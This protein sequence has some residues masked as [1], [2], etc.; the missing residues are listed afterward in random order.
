VAIRKTFAEVPAAPAREVGVAG[1]V[2]LG[3]AARA[4]LWPAQARIEGGLW[5]RR[6]RVNR[7]VSIPDGAEQLVRAG[8]LDNFRLAAGTGSGEF[9]GKYPF[10]D[11]DV[12]KWLEAAGW[13]LGREPDGALAAR[14]REIVGL[15]AAAQQPDG[16]LNTYF[17]VAKAGRRFTELDWGH[18]MYCAG[19]LIQAGIAHARGTGDTALLD[20]GRKVADNLDSEFGPDGRDGVDGHPEIETALMEL[21]RQ[22]AEKRYRDLAAFFVDRRGYRRI[23]QHHFGAAYFQDHL[24]VREAPTVA[25]HAVRQL[26]LN[27]GVTDL[28]LETGEDALRE[29]MLRQWA[30]MVATKTYVTGGLGAHHTDEAFGDAYELPPERAYCETCAAIASIQWSWRMLLHTGDPRYADLMERTLYNGFGSGV[31]LDGREYFY[32]NPLQ[33]RD[34]H[35]DGGTDQGARR[36]PWYTCACCPPNI[37]RLLA[38]LDHY[39]ATVDGDGG[40]QIHQYATGSV[41]AG[42]VELRVDTEYPWQGRIA[43]TVVAAPDREWTLS[44]RVPRWATGASATVNGE[45]VAIEP[46]YVALKQTWRAGAAPSGRLALRRAWRPGDVV[47]LDLPMPVRLTAADP[48]VDAVRGCRAIERGPLVYCLESTDQPAGVRLDDITLSTQDS[49]RST[50][51]PDLLGGVTTVELTGHH[52]P[53]PDPGWWPYGEH[54]RAAGDPVPLVAV[55]YFAWANREPGAMRIWTPTS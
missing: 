8:N 47:E 51:R 54:A 35:V 44:L 50:W 42:E 14:V 15:L 17:Q 31:S 12:Y 40:V 13:E 52:H 33:V 20:I 24:P 30:D 48:R 32:A 36:T 39:L 53:H 6:Q 19:H 55:P 43:V 21:Y 34:D 16:Y 10:Q 22:T 25:G 9:R 3:S 28:V 29:A 7:E 45:S 41:R 11:S 23:S 1:P 46:R 26:Y 49:P 5:A 2:R 37:M 27:A 4:A 18:E 38:S